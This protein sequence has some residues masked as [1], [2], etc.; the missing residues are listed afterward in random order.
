MTRS[1]FPVAALA[2][3]ILTLPSLATADSFAV[4]TVP[5]SPED[6][7]FRYLAV[8]VSAGRLNMRSAAS[9][10][11]PVT[12]RLSRETVLSHLGCMAAEGRAWC[13]VQPVAGGP[14]GFVAAE[15]LKPAIAPH[16]APLRGVNDSALRA[17]QGDF[18]ATGRIPCDATERCGFGVARAGGGDATVVVTRPDGRPPRAI[19]YTLGAPISADTSEADRAPF[20]AERS[21][22]NYHISIGSERYTLPDAIVFGG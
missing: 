8:A 4:G 9:T 21:G 10:E 7:G 13:D 16:G 5:A 1:A 3:M 15:F 18:D 19:F 6:G 22:D 17:G 14:R 11:A 2:A 12:A 20:S